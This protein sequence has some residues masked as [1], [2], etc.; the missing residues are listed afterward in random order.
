MA[1]H[2][3]TLAWKI[4]WMEEPG[5]LQSMESLRSRTR[6]RDFTFTFHFHALEKEMATHSSVLAWRIPGTG[7]PGGLQSKWLSSS[8]RSFSY[9]E[10]QLWNMHQWTIPRSWIN[11]V[12]AVVGNLFS[13]Y[14]VTALNLQHGV[15]VMYTMATL[16]EQSVRT[17]T[18]WQGYRGKRKEHVKSDSF[19]PWLCSTTV[20]GVTVSDTTWRLN[21]TNSDMLSYH[22]PDSWGWE[23]TCQ[24]W[25]PSMGRKMNYKD[26]S[27][28]AHGSTSELYSQKGNLR[29]YL[30]MTIIT[31]LILAINTRNFF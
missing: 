23:T 9:L 21:S 25:V 2:S 30:A 19:H 3:S 27:D 8:S 5:R 16:S 20:H 6:L 7:E 29:K 15:P 13:H 24:G 22:A 1:S 26:F 11:K 14:V 4:P 17:F 18:I 12:L 10:S 31:F 28:L